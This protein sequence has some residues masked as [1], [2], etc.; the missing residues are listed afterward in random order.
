MMRDGCMVC[1][2]WWWEVPY[3]PKCG[4]KLKV[5]GW[6]KECRKFRDVTR[7]KVGLDAK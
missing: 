3:C 4:W 1:A 7:P 2:P 6:C 5:S